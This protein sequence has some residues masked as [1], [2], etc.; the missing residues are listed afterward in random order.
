MDNQK[1]ILLV[2]DVAKIAGCH[3]STVMRYEEKGLIT[4]IRDEN[5][6][7]RFSLEDALYLRQYFAGRKNILAQYE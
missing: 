6:F 4:P 1:K 7:R 2:D 5:N 3:R